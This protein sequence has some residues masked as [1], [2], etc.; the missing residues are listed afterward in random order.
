MILNSLHRSLI[1]SYIF[2]PHM[3][4]TFHLLKI[5]NG[6]SNFRFLFSVD[7]IALIQ[8][9]PFLITEF[10]KLVLIVCKELCSLRILYIYIYIY[11]YICVCVC[12]CVNVI[13]RL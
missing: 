10:V 7:K 13:A 2:G 11:I 6:E 5:F 4:P 1:I 3:F 12:V 9:W 8:M